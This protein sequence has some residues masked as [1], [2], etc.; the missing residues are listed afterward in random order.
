MKG[1]F[2][3]SGRASIHKVDALEESLKL[4]PE[5][6]VHCH[7]DYNRSTRPGPESTVNLLKPLV[8]LYPDRVHVYLFKSPKLKGVME[9]IVPRRFDEGWG[10]W[11]AKIY[12]ADEELII[13]GCVLCAGYLSVLTRE[14]TYSANLNDSYFNDRQDRYLYLQSDTLAKYC[15]SFLQSMEQYCF[16]LRHDGEHATEWVNA[17][18]HPQHIEA[19]AEKTLTALQRQFMVSQAEEMNSAA[20]DE[21]VLIF[22]IIQAGQFNIREEERCM[23]MLFN[24]LDAYSK[25]SNRVPLVDLTSGYFSLTKEYQSLVIQKQI[26]CR[27]LCA[28][29]LVRSFRTTTCNS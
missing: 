23:D 10:T 19:D 22:P 14:Y 18:L 8:S 24:S 15:Q 11:H 16:K 5:L 9:K 17:N 20:T 7:L 25:A 2:H 4:N 12:S 13:T 27:I 1:T 28:S 21:D 3:T 26:D 29:P 6:H